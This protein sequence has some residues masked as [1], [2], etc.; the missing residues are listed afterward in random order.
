MKDVSSLLQ[1]ALYMGCLAPAMA[2]GESI[3]LGAQAQAQGSVQ[4][5][6]AFSQE[7]QMAHKT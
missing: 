1:G 5:C 2:S 6:S 7:A 4:L 3:G